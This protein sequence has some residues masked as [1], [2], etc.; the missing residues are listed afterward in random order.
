MASS[1]QNFK[2]TYDK[3]YEAY[4]MEFYRYIFDAIEEE[5]ELS[6][7]EA[8]TLE[9]INLLDKPTIAYLADFLGISKP[10]ATYKVSCLVE[11]GYIERLRS[12]ED[13]REYHLIPTSKFYDYYKARKN[14]PDMIRDYVVEG[15]SNEE[16][17][18]AE[19]LVAKLLMATRPKENYNSKEEIS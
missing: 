19:K 7:L 16:I 15:F 10:N 11:K 12:K 14:Y 9:V 5:E 6:P 2:N 17:E 3:L 1:Q 4:C 8:I 18:V 13:K